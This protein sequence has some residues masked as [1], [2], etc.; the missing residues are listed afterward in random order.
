M[1]AL[2]G[3]TNSSPERMAKRRKVPIFT[4]KQATG[5]LTSLEET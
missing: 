3:D 2:L 5:A 1:L 4:W